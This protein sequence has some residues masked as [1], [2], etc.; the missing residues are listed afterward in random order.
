MARVRFTR[1]VWV[2]CFALIGVALPLHQPAAKDGAALPQRYACE[3]A[4]RGRVEWILSQRFPGAAA[5]AVD[6]ARTPR[7]SQALVIED[8][9]ELK[10]TAGGDVPAS[11]RYI[12]NAFLELV[13]D[14]GW[15]T[16]EVCEV[17]RFVHDYRM[18][19]VRAQ[20]AARAGEPELLPPDVSTG[21][22]Q[23]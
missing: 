8:F 22:S 16:P 11:L 10:T 5:D 14:T 4:H 3:A 17:V 21:T 1:E 7:F 18:R 9:L 2:L 13:R 23:Q 20:A 15:V 19:A 12:D 6:A